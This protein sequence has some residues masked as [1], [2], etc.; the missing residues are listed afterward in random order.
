MN[1]IPKLC[2]AVALASVP[3]LIT[4]SYADSFFSKRK[5]STAGEIV[6]IACRDGSVVIPWEAPSRS[7]QGNVSFDFHISFILSI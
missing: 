5:D 6:P 1:R 3:G 2:S 4:Y 7:K